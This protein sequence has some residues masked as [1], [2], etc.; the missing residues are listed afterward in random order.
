MLFLIQVVAN[1]H[2]SVGLRRRGLCRFLSGKSE[3]QMG[4]GVVQEE[5]MSP[6]Q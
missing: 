3:E 4:N 5:N 6:P 2:G 1:L